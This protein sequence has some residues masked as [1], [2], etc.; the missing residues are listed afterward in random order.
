MNMNCSTV[1]RRAKTTAASQAAP[2][3]TLTS[4]IERRQTAPWQTDTCAKRRVKQ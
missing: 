4:G 1:A 2:A 3:A